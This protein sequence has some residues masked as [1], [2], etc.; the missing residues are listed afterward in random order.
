MASYRDSPG[1]SDSRGP[2]LSAGSHLLWTVI[3]ATSKT[4]RA[5]SAEAKNDVQSGQEA[6]KVGVSY[7][8]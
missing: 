6:K 8:L 4:S 7:T 3:L 1:D 2:S 5:V